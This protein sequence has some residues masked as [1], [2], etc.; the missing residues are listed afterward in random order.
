M[1]GGAVYASSFRAKSSR[2]KRVSIAL[3]CFGLSACGETTAPETSAPSAETRLAPGQVLELSCA[4]FVGVTYDALAQRFGAENIVNQ[5]LPGPEG[6]SY[7]ATV[8]FPNDPGRRLEVHW[9]DVS[10]RA[11]ISEVSV[12]GEMSDW[13]G[14]QGLALGQGIEEVERANGR[15]FQIYGFGWDYGGNV[16]DWNGGAFAPQGGCLT[17]V[18]FYAR[19]NDTSVMGDTPFLSDLPAMRAAQPR[20]SQMAIGFQE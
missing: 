4:A 17:R 15:A 2:M 5:T 6:E 11:R 20:V 10:A 13:R 9:Y 18:Q 12:S 16:S 14:P 19:T 1:V 7:E 8:L 3:I